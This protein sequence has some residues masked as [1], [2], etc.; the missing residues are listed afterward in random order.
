MAIA[1]AEAISA[2]AVAATMAMA[3]ADNNRNCG[4]R[5]QSTSG[6]GGSGRSSDS[7]RASGDRCSA[8][9]M[10]GRGAME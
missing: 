6:V 10:A 9:A 3:V 8:A 1:S 2:V 4:G 5:Q 7:G